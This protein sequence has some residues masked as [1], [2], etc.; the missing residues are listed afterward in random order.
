M[1][2][3]LYIVIEKPKAIKTAFNSKS[4]PIN[5]HTQIKR[6]S[7]KVGE[8]LSQ[9]NAQELIQEE[10]PNIAKELIIQVDGGHIPI[11]DKDRR[12]FEA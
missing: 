12:S 8:I 4:R 3:V 10:L 1:N 6:I 5:N 9:K 7:G 11:K 2:N